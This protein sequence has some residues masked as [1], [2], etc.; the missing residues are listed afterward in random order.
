M[1]IRSLIKWFL[2]VIVAGLLTAA[3]V[4]YLMVSN[5]PDKYERCLAR[6]SQQEKKEARNQFLSQVVAEFNDSA[7][8]AKPFT[9]SLDQRSLNSYLASA[10]EIAS[11]RLEGRPGEVNEAMDKAG[12]ADPAVCL[13]DGVLT[14]MARTRDYGKVVSIDLFFSFTDD[15]KLEVNIKQARIG[16]FP[17]WKSLVRGY[18]DRIKAGLSP[19]RQD[20]TEEGSA[21][22][23]LGESSVEDVGKVIKAV[24]AAIDDEPV[25]PAF[26]GSVFHKRRVRVERIEIDDGILTLHVVPVKQAGKGD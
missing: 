14:I 3:V 17:L 8:Q 21:G 15:Q 11:L 4:V 6:L 25:D 2:V 12:I 22:M 23:P 20:E 26:R 19:R 24:I 18:V 16:S 9:W 10:D 5:V 13:D 1:G 7:E